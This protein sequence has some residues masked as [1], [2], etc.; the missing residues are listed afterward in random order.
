RLCGELSAASGGAT[1]PLRVVPDSAPRAVASAPLLDAP[2]VLVQVLDASTERARQLYAKE[3]FTLEA[4]F[5]LAGR[6]QLAPAALWMNE[7]EAAEGGADAPPYRARTP[8]VARACALPIMRVFLALYAW[9]DATAREEDESTGF[10]LPNKL[11]A[12]I[13]SAQPT[14]VEALAAACHPLTTELRARAA[15]V[16]GVVARAL[17]D[18]TGAATL[19][20]YGVAAAEGAAVGAAVAPMSNSADNRAGTRA[21]T[22]LAKLSAA[23]AAS[24]AASASHPISSMSLLGSGAPAGSSSNSG[25][26][27]IATS[28]ALNGSSLLAGGARGGAHAGGSVLE[29]PRLPLAPQH[30]P[31]R[32]DTP[33]RT[34]P[35]PAT[36]GAAPGSHACIV[37]GYT[38]ALD[39]PVHAAARA[40]DEADASSMSALSHSLAASSW[41]HLVGLHHLM[42][43]AQDEAAAA[44]EAAATAAASAATAT[45]AAAAAVGDSKP[46]EV[47]SLA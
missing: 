42:A 39:V 23:A 2:S 21:R 46:R 40:V 4:A 7:E 25:S 33:V 32:A 44:A 14:S 3:A 12:R 37:A 22:E 1:A 5:R 41:Y 16:A 27:S 10:I 15:Q 19:H 9:R 38:D 31:A 47:T 11:L 6:L 8:D 26:N 17:A 36:H 24:A 34:P 43:R 29:P 18:T 45:A 13:C 35:P 28:H 30:A 20:E